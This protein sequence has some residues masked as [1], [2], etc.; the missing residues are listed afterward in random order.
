MSNTI[1]DYEFNAQ[2]SYDVQTTV[3]ADGD[4]YDSDI[5]CDDDNPLT[6]PG[7]P[8]I[9]DEK[10]NDCDLLVDEPQCA[11]ETDMDCDFISDCSDD[12]CPGTL[13][14][15]L[16][17]EHGCSANQFCGKIK[18]SGG[19][20]A[21]K[22]NNEC[23]TADWLDNEPGQTFPMM[24][25]FFGAFSKRSPRDCMVKITDYKRRRPVYSCVQTPYAN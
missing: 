1:N 24:P 8:E 10:D 16:V 25:W 15:T 20:F 2:Y 14:T 4:G 19:M 9:C 17:D 23:W 3:D 13:P 22:G 21:W 18:M 6:Y 11:Y 7:A 5:D 12:L